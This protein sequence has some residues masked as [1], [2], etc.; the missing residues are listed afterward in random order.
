MAE[1]HRWR[2]L[3]VQRAKVEQE[4]KKVLQETCDIG[5]EQEQI[6]IRMESADL[7]ARLD[8]LAPGVPFRRHGR[9]D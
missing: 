9:R 4:L 7:L 2:N 8:G 5:E 1:V 3:M 6:Q